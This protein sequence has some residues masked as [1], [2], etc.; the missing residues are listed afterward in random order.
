MRA[1]TIW[2]QR[3]DDG[4]EY[5][6][7]QDFLILPMNSI[8][9]TRHDCVLGLLEDIV[10]QPPPAFATDLI[11]CSSREDFLAQ[12]LAEIKQDGLHRHELQETPAHEEGRE[13]VS[14][15]RTNEPSHLVLSRTLHTLSTS[16]HVRLIF[17]PRID[18]LRG[19]LAGYVPRPVLAPSSPSPSP[20]L[21][22]QIIVLNLLALHQGTSEFT[23]QGLSQTLATAVSA[24]HRTR[25]AL[26]LVES[27]DVNDPSN[28][29]RGSRLWHAEVQLLSA[30]IK[31]GETG[32]NWGRRTISVLKVASRWFRVE[33]GGG[34][35]GEGGRQEEPEESEEMLV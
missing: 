21:A 34:G 33:E 13:D 9:I 18:I 20:P 11:I 32:Q 23:L 26:K 35:G 16:Q 19:Y 4:V 7:Y 6:R 29:H 24:A 8:I 22:R 3:L 27:K 30:A 12:A 31:I 25:S 15:S 10:Q 2:E 17:C 14:A 28:P 1:T 5:A